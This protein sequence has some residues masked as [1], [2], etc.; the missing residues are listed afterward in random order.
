[1]I[2]SGID[3]RNTETNLLKKTA[4]YLGNQAEFKKVET[5]R[6][7]KLTKNYPIYQFV[8]GSFI[9]LYLLLIYDGRFLEFEN[10]SLF[11]KA[12]GQKPPKHPLIS[13]I[14]FSNVDFENLGDLNNQKINTSFYSIFLKQLKEGSLKYGRRHL[15][16]QN[17]SLFFTVPNQL[18]S[19]GNPELSECKY[20]WGIVFHPDLILSTS[21]HDK[22]NDYTFLITE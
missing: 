22:I 20:S 8:F 11:N 3:H 10:I 16:F 17:G 4:L 15:D 12:L 21:L 6:M 13:I 18:V 14:D 2:M 5:K 1:M 7:E 19:I 9:I